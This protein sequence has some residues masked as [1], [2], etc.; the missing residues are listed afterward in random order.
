[1]IMFSEVKGKR[2]EAVRF[3]FLHNSYKIVAEMEEY[4]P[5]IH[6]FHEKQF[7]YVQSMDL[8]KDLLEYRKIYFGSF[9]FQEMR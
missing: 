9:I 1:M 2:T 8:D 3:Y 7:C 4:R 5:R 6:D